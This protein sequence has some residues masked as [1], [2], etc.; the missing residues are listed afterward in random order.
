MKLAYINFKHIE[1][2]SAVDL[3]LKKSSNTKLIKLAEYN[4]GLLRTI[5]INELIVVN[6]TFIWVEY[7]RTP[8][9]NNIRKI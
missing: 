6:K 3:F 2:K 7:N 9:R 1:Q 8:H 5:L 4:F